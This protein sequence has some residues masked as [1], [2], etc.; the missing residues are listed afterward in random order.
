MARI[1]AKERLDASELADFKVMVELALGTDV[2][3]L[4]DR[5]GFDD[6]RFA[7]LAMTFEV[8]GTTFWLEQ[9]N[10]DIVRLVMVKNDP[11]ELASFSLNDLGSRDIFLSALFG[12]C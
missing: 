9:V 5:V 6:G 3:E 10:G 8:D 1:K 4:M 12:L 2:L 11:H 7:G